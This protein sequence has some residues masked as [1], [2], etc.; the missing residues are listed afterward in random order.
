M[1]AVHFPRV[2]IA[3]DP[4]ASPRCIV[5]LLSKTTSADLH[6]ESAQALCHRWHD[7]HDIAAARALVGS[8]RGLVVKIALSYRGHCLPS[9]ELIGEA[10]VGLMRAVCRYDPDDGIPFATYATEWVRSTVVNHIMQRSGNDC[11]ADCKAG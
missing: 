3:G 1:P 10:Y 9:D 7:H 6:T 11:T 5:D 4:T 2:R 8:H